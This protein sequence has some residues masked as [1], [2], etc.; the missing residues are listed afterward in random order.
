MHYAFLP[1]G[2]YGRCMKVVIIAHTAQERPFSTFQSRHLSYIRCR[3]LERQEI[4]LL[5]G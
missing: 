5:L 1:A 2:I 3:N 4:A